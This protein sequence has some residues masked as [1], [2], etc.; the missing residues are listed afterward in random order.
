MFD[1]TDF[2]NDGQTELPLA[3]LDPPCGFRTT[4]IGVLEAEKRPYRVAAT[5][6]SLSGIKAAVAGG[7]AVTL[8]TTRWADNRIHDVST[9]LELPAVPEAVFSVRLRGN[10]EKNAVTLA[11]L[12]LDAVRSSNNAV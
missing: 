8:R 5:S 9:N 2:H 12:L 7:V 10:A 11:E 6:A 3:L 1:A 4:A